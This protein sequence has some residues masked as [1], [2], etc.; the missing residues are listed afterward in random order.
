[1]KELS[2]F[3]KFLVNLMIIEECSLQQAL[4]L[5]FCIYGVDRS[6]VFDLVDFLETMVHDLNI[7]HMLMNV[8][9]GQVNDFDLEGFIR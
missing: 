6:S 2:E 9:T 7:V 5:S 3:E 8:Y 1:V 4:D